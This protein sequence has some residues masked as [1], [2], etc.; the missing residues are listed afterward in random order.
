MDALLTSVR[1]AVEAV[2]EE[3]RELRELLA[4]FAEPARAVLEAVDRFADAQGEK[5]S[6]PAPV[7]KG[8]KPAPRK[9][10]DSERPT[11]ATIAGWARELDEGTRSGAIAAATGYT[12]VQVGSF[13]AGWRRNR[14]AAEQAPAE[15]APQTQTIT[16]VEDAAAVEAPPFLRRNGGAGHAGSA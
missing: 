14:P 5:A 1:T 11:D 16:I 7:S 2:R 12:P 3:N 13:V 9:A 10:T 8:K 4:A 15:A 6:E